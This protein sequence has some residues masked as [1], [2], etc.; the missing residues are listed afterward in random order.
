MKSPFQGRRR[1]SL[2]VS[3]LPL[4]LAAGFVA[5]LVPSAAQSPPSK[6]AG[7]AKAVRTPW[8]TSRVVGSPEPP[9]PY[10]SEVA[11]P[12]VK[13]FAEPLDLA[14]VPGRNRIAVVATHEALGVAGETLMLGAA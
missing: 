5:W 10:Q 3:A 7:P 4:L 9:V 8:T 12:N 2:A 13:P 11:F 6:E 1:L 14:Y